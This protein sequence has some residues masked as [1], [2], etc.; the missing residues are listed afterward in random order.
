MG[1]ATKTGAAGGS[2][3]ILKARWRMAAS[4]SARSTCTLHL[5]R[6][7][8][9]ATRSWPRTGARSRIRVSCCPAVTTSGEPALSAS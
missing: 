7:A 8:A 1:S 3:A 4:S 2:W 5:V 9:I 6:G